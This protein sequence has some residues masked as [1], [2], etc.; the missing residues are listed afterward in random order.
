MKLLLL[1]LLL[2]TVYPKSLCDGFETAAAK[3]ACSAKLTAESERARQQCLELLN[4]STSDKR[5]RLDKMGVDHCLKA[6]LAFVAD[7][8]RGRALADQMRQACDQAVIGLQGDGKKC[9]SP[10]DCAPG[11]ACLG[12]TGGPPGL[13]TKPLAKGAPCNAESLNGSALQALITAVRQ[14]CAHG[15]RC[16]TTHQG[17]T[18][19]AEVKEGAACSGASGESACASGLKCLSGKCVPDQ[20][21]ASGDPCGTDFD[22]REGDRCEQNR[23][24]KGRGAG[25]KCSLDRECQGDCVQGKCAGSC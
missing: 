10:F 25:E 12:K 20:R 14:P 24:L 19:L 13:C 7:P 9:D 6:R 11:L 8:A 16:A 2:A 18:C 21:A 22:C 4:A 23:C 3:K 15:L 17:F 5:A 1:P